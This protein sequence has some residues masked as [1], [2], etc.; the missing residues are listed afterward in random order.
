MISLNAQLS[1]ANNIR[2]RWWTLHLSTLMVMAK[3]STVIIELVENE[4]TIA[5]KSALRLCESMLGRGLQTIAIC[6]MMSHLT[7]RKQCRKGGQATH[8]ARMMM[9][10][11]LQKQR[12]QSKEA[13][14]IT[15]AQLFPR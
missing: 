9:S 14:Q 2:A 3:T 6:P 4:L 8:Q 10:D 1:L 15:R 7:R 13:L 11:E 5:K 12:A